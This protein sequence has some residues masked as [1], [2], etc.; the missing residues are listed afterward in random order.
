MQVYTTLFTMFCVENPKL[1]KNYFTY[2]VENTIINN[3]K[4]DSYRV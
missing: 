4:Y 2:N 3:V 1:G